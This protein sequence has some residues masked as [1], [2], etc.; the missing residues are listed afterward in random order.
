METTHHRA[1][2]LAI[3][4]MIALA[5]A[6]GIGRFVYTPIL[7]FM[8]DALGLT[9][10]QAGTIASANFLGYLAGALLA[11]WPRMP[12]SRRAWLLTAVAISGVST[13]AMGIVDTLFPFI[14][15]RFIGGMASAFTLVFASALVLDRLATAGRASLA[16]VHFAGVGVGIAISAILVT[17]LAA[18]T[19][20]WRTLWLA[21]G[22][23]ALLATGAVIRL[24]PDRSAEHAA[25]TAKLGR[26]EQQLYRLIAAY[27]LFGF[28]YVITAT[29]ISA[30]VR[31]IPDLQSIEP[32]IWLAFG[33]A[34]VP[35]VALWVW[36]GRIIGI[37]R[38]FALACIVEAIG[39]ATTVLTVNT[40]AVVCGAALLG[41]TFMGVTALGLM[42]ARELAGGDPRRNIGLMTAAFGLGQMI[43]P[44]F[45]GYAFDVTGS[46]TLPTLT[47]SAA[48]VIAAALVSVRFRLR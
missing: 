24:V 10:S 19:A 37:A 35:S 20:D 30:M 3:G 31:T 14:L 1:I 23:I 45:A 21:S 17:V 22:G 28:G 42:L 41:G 48:L 6:M 43:G 11:A 18:E 46:L 26:T 32:V 33:L 9:A 4:G 7:P 2:A 27:G 36:L 13:G 15:L 8:V 16:S 5:A 38:S 25:A 12:G 29:F 40:F 34:A 47:A 39:V 44:A